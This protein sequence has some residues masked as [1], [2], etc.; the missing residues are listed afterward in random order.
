MQSQTQMRNN[1]KAALVVTTF[2]VVGCSS[3]TILP[4]KPSNYGQKIAEDGGQVKQDLID[5]LPQEKIDVISDELIFFE[6][7]RLEAI[8]AIGEQQTTHEFI[9]SYPGSIRSIES[10]LNRIIV[11]VETHEAESGIP[12][13]QSII[14]YYQESRPIYDYMVDILD[15]NAD[16]EKLM[17]I[18]DFLVTLKPLGAIVFRYIK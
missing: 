8:N 18:N 10:R 2:F 12:I 1:L 14:D 5:Y 9:L 16:L 17:T 4:T 13:P 6:W 15:G 7:L 3:L 11:Q